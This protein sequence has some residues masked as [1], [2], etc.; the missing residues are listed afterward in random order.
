L[1]PSPQTTHSNTQGL[2]SRLL[3]PLIAKKGRTKLGLWL[4]L[5]LFIFSC[6]LPLMRS[7]PLKLLPFD[8]KNE[9]QVLIDMPEGSSLEKTAAKVEDVIQ[10]VKLLP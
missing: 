6:A 3:P 2:Y 9:I 7:V 10:L 5:V 4:V 1:R 8:N